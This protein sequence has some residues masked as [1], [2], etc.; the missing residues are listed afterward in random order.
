VIINGRR[1][2][3]DKKDQDSFDELKMYALAHKGDT[4]FLQ[5]RTDQHGIAV[6]ML[7]RIMDRN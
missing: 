6:K 3:G 7:G 2:L 5:M 4:G 1:D